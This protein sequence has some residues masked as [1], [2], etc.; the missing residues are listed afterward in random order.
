VNKKHQDLLE[1]VLGEEFFDKKVME[2]CDGYSLEDTIDEKSGTDLAAYLYDRINKA[3]QC[4]DDLNKAA[5]CSE[6]LMKDYIEAL[7]ECARKI[8]L[9]INPN[10]KIKLMIIPPDMY[11][12]N[13]TRKVSGEKF[14]VYYIDQAPRS[15]DTHLYG[16]PEELA[17]LLTKKNKIKY[18]PLPSKIVDK[19][20]EVLSALNASPDSEYKYTP[21][22]KL[23]YYV[24]DSVRSTQD[25]CKRNIPKNKN[26]APKSYSK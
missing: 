9:E 15:E 5:Q 2:S 26:E 17:W 21:H 8:A 7:T 10:E 19:I 23:V 4:L 24:L 14:R 6:D 3:T 20:R 13:M 22:K 12:H 1:I 18:E 25:F 11:T 16:P